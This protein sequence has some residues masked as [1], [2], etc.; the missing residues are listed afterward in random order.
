VCP[1]QGTPG[2]ALCPAVRWRAP[3]TACRSRAGPESG[4]L[5]ACRRVGRA[6]G[7]AVAWPPWKRVPNAGAERSD[8]GQPVK[9]ECRDSIQAHLKAVT[10]RKLK[11]I[12]NKTR[13]LLVFVVSMAGSIRKG[14]EN[15]CS[16]LSEAQGPSGLLMF[17]CCRLTHAK[18]PFALLADSK[19]QRTWP[20]VATARPHLLES[21][22]FSLR[23]P[24]DVL[25]AT[26][27]SLSPLSHLCGAGYLGQ[28]SFPCFSSINDLF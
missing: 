25:S 12:P 7:S 13:Y 15:R 4:L 26:L 2:L 17:G 28:L 10:C 16:L 24:R 21:S 18:I 6:R 5:P 3:P 11:K 8:V 23:Y 1:G 27:R 14:F 9:S 19:L 20:S 22:A